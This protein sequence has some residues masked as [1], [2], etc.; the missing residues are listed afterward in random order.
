MFWNA[1]NGCV[2]IDDTDMDYVSFGQGKDVF[3]MLPGLGDGL[4]TVKNMAVPLAF[5]YRMYVK[6]Y[7]VYLFSRKN[8]LT[9]GYSTKDMAA[10]LAKAMKKLNITR[11]KVLGVSQGGMIAQHLAI[12]YPDLV[13]KL[14]LAVTLSR[15]NDRVQSVVQKWIALA[16]EGNYKA[17]MVDTAEHSYSENYLKKYR[18]LYPLLGKIGKPK[19]FD[20]FIIQASSCLGH[21]TYASLDQIRCPVLVIGGDCDKIVG[22]S[23]STEMA[24][25]I[26]DCRL[27]MYQGLGHAAYEEAGDF[28]QRIL[29]F[30]RVG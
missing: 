1:K 28:H 12:D 15:Q 26:K 19:N 18:L 20:R 7:K 22:A 11:A 24:D 30:F 3:I 14:V 23:S 5:T 17:L 10:D 27:H 8:H 29:H 9:A 4:T 21:D 16:K 25:Q 6:D 2:S 13:E